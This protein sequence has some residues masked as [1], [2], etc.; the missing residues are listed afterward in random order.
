MEKL[1]NFLAY[2]KESKPDSADKYEGGVR[3]TFKEMYEK[4]VIS[5]PLKE[6]VPSEVKIAI[7]TIKKNDQ[8]QKKDDHGNH[9]YRNALDWYIRYLDEISF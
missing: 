8:F 5:K 2:L 3:N 1:D 4:G 9:M 7:E 6:M